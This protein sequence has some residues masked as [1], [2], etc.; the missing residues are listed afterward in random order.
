[1]VS[2]VFGR[3]RRLLKCSQCN[4]IMGWPVSV[5]PIHLSCSITSFITAVPEANLACLYDPGAKYFSPQGTE[6]E[7][8]TGFRVDKSYCTSRLPILQGRFRYFFLMCRHNRSLYFFYAGTATSFPLPDPNF[9]PDLLITVNFIGIGLQVGTMSDS[10]KNSVQIMIGLTNDT[11]TVVERTLGTT[12]LPRVNL[13]GVI[14][15]DS[16]NPPGLHLDSTWQRL[17]PIVL[18]KIHLD[19]T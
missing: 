12:I 15:M 1:M 13:V 4:T 14:I 6:Q 9:T 10:Y 16:M 8:T 17:Q 5:Q 7:G 2:T 18:F 11:H 19:S 3:S